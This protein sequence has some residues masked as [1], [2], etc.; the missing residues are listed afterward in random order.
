MDYSINLNKGIIFALFF[1]IY[2]LIFLLSSWHFNCAAHNS[3]I[4]FLGNCSLYKASCQAFPYFLVA[5]VHNTLTRKMHIC[6]V[7]IMSKGF[8]CLFCMLNLLHRNM[9]NA[10]VCWTGTHSIQSV[11]EEKCWTA[12]DVCACEGCNLPWS[13]GCFCILDELLKVFKV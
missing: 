4:S 5:L 13:A 9:C 1:P 6:G 3:M 2:F 10:P 12:H 11:H 7:W 8:Q